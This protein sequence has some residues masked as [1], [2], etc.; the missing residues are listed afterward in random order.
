MDDDPNIKIP[1]P[2]TIPD[3]HP[4]IDDPPVDSGLCGSV[5]CL[6]EGWHIQNPINLDQTMICQW[7]TVNEVCHIF[8]FA[9]SDWR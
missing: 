1:L 3:S 4:S 6:E 5:V 2:T 7:I 9:L 8:V